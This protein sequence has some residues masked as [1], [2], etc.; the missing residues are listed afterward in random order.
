MYRDRLRPCPGCASPL[1]GVAVAL[2]SRES[3]W[4]H[5]CEA[6]GGTFLEYFAGEPVMIARALARA[7]GRPDRPARPRRPAPCPDCERELVIRPYLDDGP[8]LWRCPECLALF[9]TAAQLRQL[10]EYEQL[11]APPPWQMLL[12]WFLPG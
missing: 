11:E 7:G 2:T 6:C 10:A 1:Q 4:A 9:A 8:L 3:S 12:D 5:V